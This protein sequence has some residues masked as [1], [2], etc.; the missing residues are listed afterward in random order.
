MTIV[1]LTPLDLALAAGLIG[2]L[3]LLS[4]RMGLGLAPRLIVA[5]MRT[6]VQLLLIGLVLKAL[7]ASVHLG[8]MA[9]MASVMLL[10]AGREVMGR[11]KRKF[12]GWWGFGMGTFSMFISSFSITILALNII[13]SVKPWYMPQ[14]A[15]PL[16]GM[17]LGNT[18]NGISIGLDR[19]TAAAWDQRPKIEGRLML[20]YTWTRAIAGIRRD[21]IRSGLIPIINSMMAAGLVSLPGMM[22]GQILGGNPPMEAVK[23]QILIMFLIAGGTGLGTVSA[24]W[25]GSR[26]LFD[27]R[28]RLRLDR[29]KN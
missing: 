6:T 2:I 19:L 20:G 11:Q 25:M 16:L 23:Y 3:A 13:I 22:T 4:W 21:S 8:W 26:R 24:V 10:V 9:V 18:M 29:L 14:Y 5:A 15:I 28:Q 27:E 7:F 12:A 1:P 17:M